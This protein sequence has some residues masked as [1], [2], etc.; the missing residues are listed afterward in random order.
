M[1]LADDGRAPCPR[2]AGLF[3]TDAVA[4]AAEPVLMIEVDRGDHGHIGVDDVDGVEPAA[5]ADFQDR[6]VE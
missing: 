2:D 5:E 3:A 1:P 6:Q 4:V